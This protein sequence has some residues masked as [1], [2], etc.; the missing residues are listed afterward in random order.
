MDEFIEDLTSGELQIRDRWQFE[1][2][3]EFFPSSSQKNSHYNQEFYFFIPNAL[4]INKLTYRKEDFYIDLTNLIR[5]KTPTF[6][7]KNSSQVHYLH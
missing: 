1:L 7:L 2:K 3:S 4:Q 6:S 5:Y